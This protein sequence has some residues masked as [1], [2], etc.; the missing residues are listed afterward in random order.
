V[1]A[2]YP[3]GCALRQTGSTTWGLT[4][5]GWMS[6]EVPFAGGSPEGSFKL[7]NTVLLRQPGIPNQTRQALPCLCLTHW[8]H[9][10][11]S[12]PRPAPDP[13][14]ACRECLVEET[15]LLRPSCPEGDSILMEAYRGARRY[16]QELRA[17]LDIPS[18]G[19]RYFVQPTLD[20]PTPTG[21]SA[22][23]RLLG[24]NRAQAEIHL[25]KLPHSL[26]LW[27]WIG[28]MPTNYSGIT[29]NPSRQIRVLIDALA[30]VISVDQDHIKAPEL[31][32]EFGGSKMV[33]VPVDLSEPGSVFGSYGG[34]DLFA[35]E[36]RVVILLAEE[37]P[38]ATWVGNRDNSARGKQLQKEV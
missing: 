6:L 30:G 33:R 34:S 17:R 36:F 10:S 27:F 18:M 12:Q 28:I 2:T 15:D 4:A 1:C 14:D 13:E 16:R 9:P 35:G 24:G 19:P 7:P 38:P 32:H 11:R 3:P 8:T 26:V 20:L 22:E 29:K 23:V 31:L 5:P 25:E 21:D 37:L